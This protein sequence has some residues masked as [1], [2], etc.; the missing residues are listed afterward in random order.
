MLFS[1]GPNWECPLRNDLGT[2]GLPT[3]LQT[4]SCRRASKPKQISLCFL[5]GGETRGLKNLFVCL[6]YR[7]LKQKAHS[8]WEI[9]ESILILSSS[10]V[11]WPSLVN[12]SVTSTLREDAGNFIPAASSWEVEQESP[13]FCGC[14]RAGDRHQPISCLSGTKLYWAPLIY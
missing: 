1:K 3:Y 8:E 9:K 4:E 5:H 14:M 12:H 2:S 7:H 10:L 11:V 6:F 13:V